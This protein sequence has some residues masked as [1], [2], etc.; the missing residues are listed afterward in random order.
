MFYVI[1]W[2]LSLG[3]E[4]NVILGHINRIAQSAE[5]GRSLFIFTCCCEYPVEFRKMWA[6][7]KGSKVDHFIN[8]AQRVRK[9]DL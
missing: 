4:G 5:H 6:N 2:V 9:H 1:C 8:Y 7:W 3:K